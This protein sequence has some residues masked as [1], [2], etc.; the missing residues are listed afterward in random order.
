MAI[1]KLKKLRLIG[2]NYERQLLLNALAETNAVHVKCDEDALVAAQENEKVADISEKADRV[3]AAIEFIES[4]AKKNDKD[5]SPQKEPLNVT[6]DGFM[7]VLDDAKALQNTVEEAEKL[8]AAF[9]DVAQKSLKIKTLKTQVAGYSGV[10]VPF[11]RVKN[12]KNTVAFLGLISSGGINRLQDFVAENCP[13]TVIERLNEQDGGVVTFVV[14]HNSEREAVASKLAELNF[15]RCPFDYDVTP[16]KK[17]KELE[18]QEKELAEKEKQLT[19]DTLALLGKDDDLKLYYD[20]LKFEK[21]KQE[22]AVNFEETAATFTLEAYVPEG[23]EQAVT[24]KINEKTQATY[25][26]FEDAGTGEEVPTLMKNNK[27]VRQFEF[28]TNMYSPPAYK[29]Y[30][31]NTFVS[32]FFSIF[33][34]FI[35]ADIGYGI[36]LALGGL[37]LASRKKRD[38]GMRRLMYIIGIGGLFTILFGIMFGSFFGLGNEYIKW[39]PDPIFPDPVSNCSEVLMYSLMFGVVH[40]AFAY[41]AKGLTCIKQGSVWDG[42]WDGFLWAVFFVGLGLLFPV[43]ARLFF[44]ESTTLFGLEEIPPMLNYVG[45]GICIGVL[46]IEIFAAGRH[47]RFFGKFAKAFSTVYGLINFFSDLLSYARLYGLMLSGAMIA[48]IVSTMSLDLMANGAGGFVGG[49]LVLIVGHAFNIAM[50]TLGAYVHN[51][52]LQFIEFFGK[53]YE[54]NG[55][56]FTPIGSKLS[57]TEVS[58]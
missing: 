5:F 52:R 2:I 36:L 4:T 49:I 19:A 53:F 34:G 9:N 1:A 48:E 22:Y 17:V 47:S 35:M 8:K 31:P 54:G 40:L 15:V 46:V 14:C 57:Y 32:I 51:A 55:E 29:E 27:V 41:I 50:G 12:T 30:D 6:F 10:D 18:G 25:F 58:R 13:L 56:L 26:S 43:G 20:R 23:E 24:E 11:N 3:E 44:D 21:Q 33:F 37:F 42:I 38:T 45:G 28:V 7:D 16:E 39:L